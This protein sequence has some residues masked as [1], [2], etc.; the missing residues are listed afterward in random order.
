MLEGFHGSAPENYLSIVEAG[1]DK[2]RRGTA[3]GQIFGSGEYFAKSPTVSM[4]YCSGGEYMLVG[5]L[6]LGVQ[7]SSPDNEDGDHIWVPEKGYYIVSEPEQ[8]L[9]QFLVKFSTGTQDA[10]T[11]CPQLEEALESGYSTKAA[12]LVVAVP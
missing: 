5:R 11:K 6:T 10:P 12:E 1:F 9:P 4:D 3:V 8:I 2:N 7:S